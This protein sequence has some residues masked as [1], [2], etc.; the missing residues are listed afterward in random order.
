MCECIRVD[1]CV[2][3]WVRANVYIYIYWFSDEVYIYIYIYICVCVYI[4]IYICIYNFLNHVIA[5]L[6]LSP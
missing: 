1:V 4:Y 5:L 3:A 2:R 6:W